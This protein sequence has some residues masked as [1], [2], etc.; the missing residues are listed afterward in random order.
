MSIV[1]QTEAGNYSSLSNEMIFV[2]YEATKAPDDVTYPNY[3]YVCDVYVNS[4]LIGRLKTRPD[5]TYKKGIFD[6]SALL[7]SYATSGLKANYS[8]LV[9]S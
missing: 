8:K 1:L 6:V 4:V 2:A 7:Q 3:Q 5:P 9:E